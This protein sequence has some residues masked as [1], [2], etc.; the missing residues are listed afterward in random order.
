MTDHKQDVRPIPQVAADQLLH[1]QMKVISI[2]TFLG[3]ALV[4]SLFFGMGV[5]GKI[6]DAAASRYTVQA[7]AA[8]LIQTPQQTSE[9]MQ[10]SPAAS[11]T[12]II[13]LHRDEMTKG[14]V[15]GYLSKL[16]SDEALALFREIV[17]IPSSTS[18]QSQSDAPLDTL[19]RDIV[20][21]GSLTKDDLLDRL[22]LLSDAQ[23]DELVGRPATSPVTSTPSPTP[24]ESA[25]PLSLNE[26]Y[27]VAESKYP[28]QVHSDRRLSLIAERH[29][30]DY[31]FYVT[32]PGD[33]LLT[34]SR[35]FNVPLG[36]LVDLNGIA[37]ADLIHAGDV[38]LFPLDTKQP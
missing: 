7:A 28:G 6:A 4:L 9:P 13:V 3:S 2:A 16:P 18:P 36:Q 30:M 22:R 12:K 32:E 19:R 8:P 20:L 34:L 26:A 38:L 5:P 10:P 21:G 1:R 33:T 17:V 35:S 27:A 11:D 37:D 31:R 15:M 25:S 24:L 23:F 14:E 29:A